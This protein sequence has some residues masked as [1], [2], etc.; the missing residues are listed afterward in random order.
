MQH[1]TIADA[2]MS[3]APQVLEM[4]N[5]LRAPV[6]EAPP[7]PTFLQRHTKHIEWTLLAL[8][9]GAAAWFVYELAI[10]LTH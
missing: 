5:T 3:P 2:P 6:A 1:Y 7:Q 4:I 9:A 10:Y 8:V